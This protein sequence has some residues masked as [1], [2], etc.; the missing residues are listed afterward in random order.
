LNTWDEERIQKALRE[1]GTNSGSFV[2]VHSD[3]QF[4]VFA[5]DV[6][7]KSGEIALTALGRFASNLFSHL[8]AQE[9]G[10]A[11]SLISR[12]GAPR[13]L[14]ELLNVGGNVDAPLHTRKAAGGSWCVGKSNL[15]DALRL[16]VY[17]GGKRGGEQLQRSRAAFL[18]PTLLVAI[19]SYPGGAVMGALDFHLWGGLLGGEFLEPLVAAGARILEQ[20]NTLQH[21]L[22]AAVDLGSAAIVKYLLECGVSPAGV[23]AESGGYSALHR[24]TGDWAFVPPPVEA[25]GWEA[26]G[27]PPPGALPPSSLTTTT[28]PTVT[29]LATAKSAEDA[30]SLTYRPTRGMLECLLTGGA[31]PRAVDECGRTTLHHFACSNSKCLRADPAGRLAIAV[32][33]LRAGAD[34]DAIDSAGETAMTAGLRVRGEKEGGRFADALRAEAPGGKKG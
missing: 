11:A 4:I 15:L 14:K 30:E 25:L 33:L 13:I 26:R 9:T 28:E 18:L 23:R 1:K 29:A 6:E 19:S 5:P 10:V 27:T 32:R 31:D 34:R 12:E 7:R 3:E 21:P 22:I 16:I 2:E 24:L 8:K 20:D 17:A